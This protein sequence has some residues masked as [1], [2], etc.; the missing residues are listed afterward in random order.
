MMGQS[1]VS[2]IRSSGDTTALMRFGRNNTHGHDDVLAYSYYAGGKEISAD[3][4]YSV[5]GTNAHY[6]WAS[7]SIAHNTVVVNQDE[8]MK[9]T[10]CSRFFRRRVNAA[11]FVR[12]GCGDGRGRYRIIR[13]MRS[14]AIPAHD[15]TCR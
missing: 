9:K 4:G 2:I 8:G 11:V 13:R 1:G 3:I 5:Y 10:N 7:K 15:R 14:R 6:G 12:N